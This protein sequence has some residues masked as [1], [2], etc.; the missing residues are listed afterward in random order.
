[1]DKTKSEIKKNNANNQ[2]FNLNDS[3][4]Q[5]H[6][7]SH[8]MTNTP[9]VTTN[10][11][12][13]VHSNQA[14]E[15][16]A[17][18]N[19]G[20]PNLRTSSLG[21]NGEQVV[22]GT[23]ICQAQVTE[24]ICNFLEWEPD[25]QQLDILNK[26]SHR[27]VNVSARPTIMNGRDSTQAVTNQAYTRLK[28]QLVS[29]V[30][31][32]QYLLFFDCEALHIFDKVLYSQL[33]LFPSEIIGI[34]DTVVTRCWIEDILPLQALENNMDE[35]RKAQLETCNVKTIPVN[36]KRDH[37]RRMRDLNTQDVQT[38]VAIR[39]LVL[40][41]SEIMPEMAQG[42]FVCSMCTNKVERDLINGKIS[43]PR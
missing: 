19:T 33:I 22:W 5:P 34:F 29:I 10:E 27:S 37:V 31:T 42:H 16:N 30:K 41:T 35:S 2:R 14:N 38:M 32:N 13:T 17:V 36:F 40:R 24:K 1:M 12:E 23:N 7:V 21:N 4:L 9:R 15:N 20:T 43:E 3:Y 39:G 8:N 11:R 26:N 28:E 25:Q 6:S 18:N